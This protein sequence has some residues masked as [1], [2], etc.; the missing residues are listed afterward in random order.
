MIFIARTNGHF[1]S[2]RPGNLLIG[3][4]LGTQNVATIIAVYGLLILPIG[5]NLAAMVWIYAIIVFLII[6]QLKVRYY[7]FFDEGL[8]LMEKRL[9]ANR[10][11][12][13]HLLLSL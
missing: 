7:K 10:S 6:D 12:P 8:E 2:Y 11:S 13:F 3:A 5:W 1:W 4:V 9:K